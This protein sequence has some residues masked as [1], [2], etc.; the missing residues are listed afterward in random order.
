MKLPAILRTLL[1]RLNPDFSREPSLSGPV[2]LRELPNG[3]HAFVT[4]F[5]LP[6]DARRRLLELGFLPGTVL[7]AV[8]RAPLGDPLQVEVRGYHLSLRNREASGIR[9]EI[10]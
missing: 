9:I 3:A 4:G 7:H 8:R 10:R 5:D 2:N 6:V 1:L